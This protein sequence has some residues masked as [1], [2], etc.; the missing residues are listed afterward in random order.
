M[1]VTVDCQIGYVYINKMLP[2]FINFVSA[3]K[4]VETVCL[5]TWLL[6]DATTNLAW[7]R[8]D[9]QE[10]VVSLLSFSSLNIPKICATSECGPSDRIS[11]VCLGCIPNCTQSDPL[12][13]GSPKMLVYSRCKQGHRATVVDLNSFLSSSHV[14]IYLSA[15]SDSAKLTSSPT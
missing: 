6:N 15:T 1:L 10:L 8:I 12:V 4:L 13:I 3:V 7:L 11:I 5:N 2:S 14:L 9:D